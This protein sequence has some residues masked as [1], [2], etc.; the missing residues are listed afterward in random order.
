MVKYD[1]IRFVGSDFILFFPLPVSN[2][3]HYCYQDQT[4]IT[5]P[6]AADSIMKCFP[7]IRESGKVFRGDN[8]L[9][10]VMY[11]LLACCALCNSV[12][13]QQ[14]WTEFRGPNGTGH[15]INSEPP[16]KWS[17]TENIK[18]KTAIH[19]KSW[20]SPVISQGRI[21]LTSATED[22]KQ[23][24]VICVDAAS[25]KIIHD[26]LLFTNKE[27]QDIDVTNSYASPTAVI[28]GDRVYV[29]FGS[30]GTV[31]LDAQTAQTIWERKDFPCNHWRGPGSSPIIYKNLLFLHFDGY[32]FQYIVALDKLTGKTVWKKDR[33][34]LY[35]TDNGDHKKAFATP[36]VFEID[37]QPLLISPYAKTVMAYEPLT[38][39]EIWWVRFEQHSAANRPLYDGRRIYIGT[40][41]GKGNVIAVDPKGAKGNVTESHIQWAVKRAMPSKPSQLLIDGKIYTVADKN[42][43]ISCIDVSTGEIL[44]QDRIGGTFSASPVY[45][46]GH[47][48]FCDEDG[49][50]TVIKPG[51]SLNIV[52]ENVLDAGCMATPAPV[53]KALF[54]RTRTNLYRIEK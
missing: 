46:A 32:D 16:V 47:I 49:K 15:A 11:S 51:T 37:G 43:I 44:W 18:W 45:A 36:A 41:F 54:L 2:R 13:A 35:E 33:M 19:G 30:F 34:D 38:G 7:V 8:F 31:C 42:G 9:S 17:E 14:G 25:G 12:S 6:Q 24:F 20:S 1:M 39:K 27:P 26:R 5:K 53:G 22:G 52:A 21:W 28:D 48:Y 10:L 29:H 50:T 3:F 23:M 4:V 40:G